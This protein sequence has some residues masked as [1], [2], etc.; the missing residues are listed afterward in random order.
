[1]LFGQLAGL[2]KSNVPQSS[3]PLWP[4]QAVAR[5]QQSG[6]LFLN[7]ITQFPLNKT[8]ANKF[9]NLANFQSIRENSFQWMMIYL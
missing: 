2:P 3:P 1:L 8:K 9:I 4:Q 5:S 6:Q 7:R